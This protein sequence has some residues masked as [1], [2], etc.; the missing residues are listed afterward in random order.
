MGAVAPVGT[1]AAKRV[2]PCWRLGVSDKW[3]G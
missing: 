3:N 1:W 2:L